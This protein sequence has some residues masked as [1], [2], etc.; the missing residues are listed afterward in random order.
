AEQKIWFL[1]W[2][3][4]AITHHHNPLLSTYLNYPDGFNL[5]WNTAMPAAGVLL[6]P[7]TALWSAV[8]T[9]NV[10][11]TVAIPLA[12]FLAFLAIRRHVD[13]RAACAVGALLYG[14]SPAM[15][16]QEF[17]HAT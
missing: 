2:P 6:W 16:A 12:A 13:N 1:S 5:L 7:V 11:T 14:F 15:M 10:I 17:G 8:A 9:Y 3:P 4:F